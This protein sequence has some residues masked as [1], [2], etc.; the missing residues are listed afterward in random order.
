MTDKIRV[1][2][3]D[4]EEP[5]VENMTRILKFRGF[6][7][8]TALSGYQALDAVKYAGGFDV[9]VLDIK[10]PGMDG[11]ETL[12]LIKRWAPD[13]EVIMLTG[14]ASL[15]S[16]TQALTL[17]AYDYLM[18][19]CDVEDLVEKIREA[20][21]AE[22]IKRHPVLWPRKLVREIALHPVRGLDP[23][24]LLSEALEVMRR[25]VGAE[26][27]EEVFV[28][29]KGDRLLGVITKRDLVEAAQRAHPGVSLNWTRLLES[30]AWLPGKPLKEMMRH[31]PVATQGNAFLTDAAN[32]MIVHNVRSMPV[33]RAGKVLG[34]IH[35]QDVFQYLDTEME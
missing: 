5:F 14:H 26:A 7:V 28:L 22:S 33:L 34:V 15:S 8:T 9:V 27:V 2:L 29:D 17:G 16:G 21:E 25:D 13:T 19:P 11:L 30:L 3:V 12:G 23:E 6:E 35:L 31:D 32:Q 20:Y 24:A 1:L 18:K 10:M 4:D